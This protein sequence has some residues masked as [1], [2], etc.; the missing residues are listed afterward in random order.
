MPNEI[1]SGLPNEASYTA[2][3]DTIVD[4]RTCLEWQKSAP[5]RMLPDLYDWTHAEDYC[6]KLVLGGHDDWRLPTRI[7][8]VSIARFGAREGV[9]VNVFSGTY[10]AGLWTASLWAPVIMDPTAAGIAWAIFSTPT[11]VQSTRE[12]GIEGVRCVRGGGAGEAPNELA[13]APADL[14][15][16]VAFGEVRDN[17]TGLV[18]QQGQSG[19]AMPYEDAGAYCASLTLGGHGWRL[20]SAQE[21]LTLVDETESLHAINLDAFP[22]T[23]SVARYW[24][25]QPPSDVPANYRVSVNSSS[26]NLFF[27]DATGEE[28][29]VRCVR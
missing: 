17:Y 3:S 4:E 18:W 8:L 6:D 28:G 21:F 2:T 9:D 20:P 10:E 27:E 5:P 14:Y 1:G 25:A 29:F 16:N 24:C 12:S 11:S 26:G 15:T 7:E 23:E 13:A 22:D 19:A